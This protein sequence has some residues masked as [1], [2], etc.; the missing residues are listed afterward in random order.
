[1]TH[2]PLHI[3]GASD[4]LIELEGALRDELNPPYN[5]P[6]YLDVVD[7]AGRVLAH[8][9]AE[10]DPDGSG[11]WRLT[12]AATLAGEITHHPARGEDAEPREDE[13]GCPNYSDMVT[14]V[15][16]ADPIDHVDQ[17]EVDNR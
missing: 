5:K 9:K 16:L 15:S 6:A 2:P 4:D 7:E 11:C 13:H 14:V 12:A 8:V 10:Y 1:M 17:R 3:Y